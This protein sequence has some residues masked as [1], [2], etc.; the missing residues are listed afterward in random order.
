MDILFSAQLQF[1]PDL[2]TADNRFSIVSPPQVIIQSQ[3]VNWN[4]CLKSETMGVVVSIL[5]SRA[6]KSEGW[7]LQALSKKLACL[8]LTGQQL[9]NVYYKNTLVSPN[10]LRIAYKLN[11]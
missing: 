7:M 10:F 1:E 4:L 5:K 9:L 2:P 11:F 6:L 8:M 3:F